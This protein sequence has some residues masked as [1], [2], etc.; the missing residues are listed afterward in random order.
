V[1]TGRVLRC[2]AGAFIKVCIEWLWSLAK[3]DPVS[4]CQM[5]AWKQACRRQPSAWTAGPAFFLWLLAL[6]QNCGWHANYVVMQGGKRCTALVNHY[7]KRREYYTGNANATAE[8]P[9]PAAGLW[10]ALGFRAWGGAQ[11][12]GAAAWHDGRSM[13]TLTRHHMTD[14]VAKLTGEAFQPEGVCVG[15]KRQTACLTCNWGRSQK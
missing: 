15:Y 5:P 12:I 1:D 4:T 8:Q 13:R 3:I 10:V 2:N 9:R 6:V 11:S 7:T 14:T